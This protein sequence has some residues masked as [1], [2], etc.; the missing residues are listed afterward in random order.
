M[1]YVNEIELI[2]FTEISKHVVCYNTM[3]L[4]L[5][6]QNEQ[7]QNLYEILHKQFNN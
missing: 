2:Y 3:N 6:K 1:S 4:Q 7:H 5:N